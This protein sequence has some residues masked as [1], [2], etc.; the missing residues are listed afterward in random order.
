MTCDD[1][2]VSDSLTGGTLVLS[3]VLS[4][5]LSGALSNDGG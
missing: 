4:G 5:A 2:T 3:G 1:G